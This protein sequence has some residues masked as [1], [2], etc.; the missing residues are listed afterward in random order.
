MQQQPFMNQEIDVFADIA[1]IESNIDLSQVR[2]RCEY[3]ESLEQQKDALSI[4]LE[5]LNDEIKR[6][7]EVELPQLMDELQLASFKLQSG[8][9]ILV[10]EMVFASIPAKNADMAFEWLDANGH[11]DLIKHKLEHSFD[12]GETALVKQVI[13]VLK[14]QGLPDVTTKQSVHPQTL[15]AFAREQL[16][17]GRAIPMELLGVHIARKVEIKTSKSK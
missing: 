7:K 17:D 15:A 10:K 2:E 1:N 11:G 8:R 9:E 5:R 14:E 6:L 4:E 3:L 16:K 13:D 12:R